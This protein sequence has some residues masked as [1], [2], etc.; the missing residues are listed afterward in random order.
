MS[1]K[2]RDEVEAGIMYTRTWTWRGLSSA[3]DALGRQ[4]Y[5]GM[6]G[7]MEN[8]KTLEEGCRPV[9]ERSCTSW[10]LA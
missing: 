2:G 5:I 3:Q 9:V 4:N 8:A 6:H 10:S 7:E 1:L